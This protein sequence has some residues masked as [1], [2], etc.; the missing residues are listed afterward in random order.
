MP[1]PL[2]LKRNRVLEWLRAAHRDPLFLASVTEADLENRNDEIVQCF[3]TWAGQ[4]GFT[5]QI[6]TVPL[7]KAEGYEVQWMHRGATFVG[8]RQ[9]PPEAT[10]E[11]A[12]LAGCAALL[13]NDWCRKQLPK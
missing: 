7:G 9:P 5:F 12:L 8:F 10:R 2:T 4:A 3:L 13:E 6:V 11:D 1:R